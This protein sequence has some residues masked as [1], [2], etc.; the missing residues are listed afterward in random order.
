MK[1]LWTTF[2]LIDT[3]ARVLC[4]GEGFGLQNNISS[5]LLGHRHQTL[6]LHCRIDASSS[7][8]LCSAE[9]IALL[10]IHQRRGLSSKLP[11]QLEGSWLSAELSRCHPVT[12][13]VHSRTTPEIRIRSIN[14]DELTP[15]VCIGNLKVILSS[16]VVR[17]SN[18]WLF[19]QSG[20]S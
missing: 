9:T 3:T 13:L 19:P 8:C 14:K 10:F 4:V 5:P 18:L 6:F 20:D 15:H 1:I 12:H 11:L 16:F 17:M 7:S 2:C